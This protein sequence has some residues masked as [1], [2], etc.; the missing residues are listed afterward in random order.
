MHIIDVILHQKNPKKFPNFRAI[1]WRGRLLP[2]DRPAQVLPGPEHT[3]CAAA[4]RET[5][6]MDGIQNLNQTFKYVSL[7]LD[8]LVMFSHL[9]FQFLGYPILTHMNKKDEDHED[10]EDQ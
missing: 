10:H 7:G 8:G 4:Q 5:M 9:P 1:F 6:G 3:R 2:A